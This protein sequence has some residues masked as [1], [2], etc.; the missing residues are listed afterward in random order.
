MRPSAGAGGV[1]AEGGDIHAAVGPAA[2]PPGNGTDTDAVTAAIIESFHRAHRR[3]G[4]PTR[5]RGRKRRGS[6]RSSRGPDRST[7][8]GA[9]ANRRAKA[10]H[11][12][13]QQVRPDHRHGCGRRREKHSQTPSK[14]PFVPRRSRGVQYNRGKCRPRSIGVLRT[15]YPS[16]PNTSSTVAAVMARRNHSFEL[17][18]VSAL[19]I[20]RI[21]SSVTGMLRVART[22]RALRRDLRLCPC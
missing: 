3:A 20:R 13:R 1:L 4:D 8:R 7:L 21:A 9:D 14:L 6:P 16:A 12:D 22:S 11:I 17:V 2:I 18:D 10:R 5:R 19:M 15:A